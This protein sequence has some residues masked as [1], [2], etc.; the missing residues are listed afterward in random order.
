MKA[1]ALLGFAVWRTIAAS[2]WPSSIAAAATVSDDDDLIEADGET[3][4]AAARMWKAAAPFRSSLLTR[5]RSMLRQAFAPNRQGCLQHPLVS[6]SRR[7][8]V[9]LPSRTTSS[10]LLAT[11]ESDMWELRHKELTEYRD[12]HGDCNVP[13]SQGPLGNWV[14]RQRRCYKQGK[15]SDERIVRLESIGF[16]WNQKQQEWLDH[17]KELMAYKAENGDCNVPQ[18]QGRL[19]KWVSNRRQEFKQGKLSDERIARLEGIGFAW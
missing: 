18:S 17:F 19:G 14:N 10:L 13:R 9:G 2:S 1:L 5:C 15:L 3:G 4:N 11:K 7:R 12:G 16:V 6:P 8:V